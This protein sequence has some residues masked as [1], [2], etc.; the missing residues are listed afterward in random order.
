[1]GPRLRVLVSSTLGL[2]LVTMAFAVMYADNAEATHN[3]TNC[4]W[5]FPWPADV[6]YWIDQGPDQNWQFTAT[7]AE[8]VEFGGN[9][10][11]NGGF[12]FL[13][14]RVDF[15][16]E[17]SGGDYGWTTWIGRDEVPDGYAA[18]AGRHYVGSTC[19]VDTGNYLTAANIRFNQNRDFH[20]DCLAAGDHCQI[21]QE[22]DIHNV[23]SH[24]FGHWV[25]LGDIDEPNFDYATMYHQITE[26]GETQKRSLSWYDDWGA[27]VMYG[28]R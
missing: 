25:Y 3:T 8:R 23:A 16:W 20:I 26:W 5:P 1:V 27:E 19:N 18:V 15:S 13:F 12:N 17:S 21:E 7:E 14:H 9:T 11:T 28:Y 22:H 4:K 6:Y 24:E 10:W 2:I